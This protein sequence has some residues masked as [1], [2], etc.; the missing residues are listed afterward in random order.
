MKLNDTSNFKATALG[1]EALRA[2]APSI[3]ASGPVQGV[4]ERYT[5]VPTAELVSGLREHDWVPVE[6]EEQ[7][8][9]NEARR[10]FQKHLIRF[11]RS[12]QMA[13]LDEWNVELVLLNSHGRGCAYQLHA[14]IYRRICSNGLVLSEGSF[15]AIRF[16]HAGLLQDEVVQASFRV[17]DFV[18]KVGEL[19]NRF[20]SRALEVRESLALAKHALVM[21]YG[22]LGAAPVEPDTLL[23]ARRPEDEGN[24]PL[25]QHESTSGEFDSRRPVGVP[26]RPPG[27]TP[28]GPGVARHQLQGRD[29]Q[30]TLGFGGRIS[31]GETLPQVPDCPLP[32][33]CS[34]EPGAYQLWFIKRTR[35]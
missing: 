15:Q 13:T 29:Q 4:S 14:G 5:F 6:V 30:G 16:R 9:R 1:E 23:K 35:W 28:F 24:G 2:Q 31:N 33:E 8:I 20:R 27:E 10:G 3:F 21:R 34:G 32:L 18:P 25:D 26:S 22:S 11:R 7:R 12:E 17:L 19:V